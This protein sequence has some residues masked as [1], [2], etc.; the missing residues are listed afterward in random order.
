MSNENEIIIDE[1]PMDAFDLQKIDIIIKET[2][3]I[4]F[5]YTDVVKWDERHVERQLAPE[6][7]QT[8]WCMDD[9]MCVEHIEHEDYEEVATAI[10]DKILEELGIDIE[11]EDIIDFIERKNE[12]TGE[13]VSEIIEDE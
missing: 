3:E 4:R 1:D 2:G 11:V 8:Q 7:V 6:V 9:E 13:E 10:H 12:F 5:S